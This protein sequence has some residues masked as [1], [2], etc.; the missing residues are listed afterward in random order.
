MQFLRNDVNLRIFNKSELTL[1]LGAIRGVEQTPTP[2]QDAL[3][4]AVAALHGVDLFPRGLPKPAHAVLAHVFRDARCRRR[5]LELAVALAA[6][7]GELRPPAK[8]NLLLLARNLGHTDR[9]VRVL[10]DVASQHYLHGRVDFTRRMAARLVGKP[11]ATPAERSL[12]G[13]WSGI[14]PVGESSLRSARY[15][16]L[17]GLERHS[18]GYALFCHYRGNNFRFPG[19]DGGMAERLLGHDVGHVLAGYATDPQGELQH[20]A[21]QTGCVSDDGF[22]RL[23]FGILEFQFA[24]RVTAEVWED[25]PVIDVGLVTAAIARGASCSVDLTRDWDFVPLFP[26]PLDEVRRLLG[27]RPFVRDAVA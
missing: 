15:H 24:R 4:T 19:E 20:A 14:W 26:K 11:P 9:D 16:A 8:A 27:V 23:Y 18:F 2:E 22:M 12:H 7:D 3:L 6:A 10:R 25:A 1:A 5:L 21:F 17:E 13:L